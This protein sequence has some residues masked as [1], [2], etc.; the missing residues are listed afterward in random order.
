MP[1][2]FSLTTILDAL[3]GGF[4]LM[5]QH[6]FI[7]YINEK[8][9]LACTTQ[10]L[11]GP[12]E[13]LG[14]EW[15]PPAI[16]NTLNEGKECAI[17]QNWHGILLDWKLMLLA[18]GFLLSVRES[19]QSFRALVDNSP[20]II[21]RYDLDLRCRFLNNTFNQY[22]TIPAQEHLG[23]LLL[24]R[25]LPSL[26]IDAI[27][28]NANR[29]LE[30]GQPQRFIN[31]LIQPDRYCVFESRLLPERD[32]AGEIQSLLCIDRD[33]TDFHA[34]RLWEADENRLLEMIAND[35]PLKELFVW[36]CQM[37]ESQL[38]GSQCAIMLLDETNQCLHVA[39]APSMDEGYSKAVE[40]VAIGEGI[41]SCGTA[42]ARAS[43]VIVSDIDNDP[44]WQN[45]TGLTK[46]YGLRACWSQPILAQDGK[47]LGTFAVYHQEIYQPSQHALDISRRTSHLMA[48]AIQQEQRSQTLYKLA[49]QD[50]LT[51]LSNRR[52]FLEQASQRF[53]DA[54]LSGKP[55][56][57]LMLD[58]D[59][60]K[61]VNDTYGH[62]SGDI[63]LQNFA[64]TLKSTLRAT[65]LVCRMGGEEFAALL[66]DT[67]PHEMLIVAN[68][69]CKA[70]SALVI[71][72][73]HQPITITV[74][75][76]ATSLEPSCRELSELIRRS[77][78]ALYQAKA[79]GRNR[80][81][82]FQ[83]Q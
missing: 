63:V 15:L 56:S 40:G 47:V 43:L 6:Q 21:T 24:E 18:E 10:P 60:F 57:L 38:T 8:F 72:H 71:E 77:D 1:Q 34:T 14:T 62:E 67:P 68:R 3:P 53:R 42:A 52:H 13:K 5:D 54:R 11:P 31:E 39:A 7:V 35:R 70:T 26:Q 9:R 82:T 83:E 37:I 23:L 22:S 12:G 25:P 59:H 33:I 74:S 55:L 49:T 51:G 30:T 75:V 61:Q 29:V 28:H 81:S 78:K 19:R 50:G 20:D 36:T 27:A 64:T 2:S 69:I 65:D 4:A 66:P 80:V 45:Y 46:K 76:G 41:G 58:L 44:L 17:T 16:Q 32:D 79:E 73:H 48:I